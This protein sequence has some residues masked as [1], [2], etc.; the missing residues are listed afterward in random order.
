MDIKD[1]MPMGLMFVVSIIALGIG[2]QVVANVQEGH[3]T[4]TDGCNSTDTSACG[5]A[6]DAA[7]SGMEGL[8][9]LGDWYP[10]IGLVIAASIVIG[11]LVYSFA[12]RD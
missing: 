4:N 12:M 8:G 10:T 3:V 2:A 1:L 9:E 6:Y 5:Y 7:E 11:V